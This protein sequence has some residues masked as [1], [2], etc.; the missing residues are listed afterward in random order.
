MYL[1]VV[2]DPTS[3]AVDVAEPDDC[4]RFHVEAAGPA[5]PAAL[6]AALAATGTGVLE[7]NGDALVEISAVRRLVAGRVA[8]DWDS[9]FGDMLHYATARGWVSEDGSAIRAHVEWR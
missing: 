4:G 2:A 7:A 9:R 8:A 6:D 5:D 1:T 3:P